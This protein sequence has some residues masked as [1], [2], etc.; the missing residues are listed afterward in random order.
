MQI[1]E[2]AIDRLRPDAD[3]LLSDL[4]MLVGNGGR[5]RTLDEYEAL[6]K[7]AEFRLAGEHCT[8]AGFSI[9]EAVPA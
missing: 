4:E 5:E 6:L 2:R 1:V 9:L 3:I 8:T 7:Q